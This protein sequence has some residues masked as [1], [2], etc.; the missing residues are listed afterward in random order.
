MS[1]MTPISKGAAF[2]QPGSDPVPPEESRL[3]YGKRLANVQPH[4]TPLVAANEQPHV[5]V[6]D[7][8]KRLHTAQMRTEITGTGS[9]VDATV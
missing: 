1:E 8:A 4:P 3:P 5:V 6:D 7:Q 2:V 9:L